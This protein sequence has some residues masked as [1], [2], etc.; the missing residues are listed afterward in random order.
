MRTFEPDDS[1]TSADLAGSVKVN[2]SGW[3]L[4]RAWN[5]EAHP[6][7]FDLYPYATTSPV[8]IS[9]NNASPHAPGDADYFLAWIG[10]I[11]ES[12][13]SHIHFND[14]S[15]RAAILAHLDL[16]EQRYRSCRQ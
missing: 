13:K 2:E 16:A 8:F 6:L 14:D 3:M 5:D 4:L 9:V 15:E 12:V 1:R 11:R 10:R 7:V